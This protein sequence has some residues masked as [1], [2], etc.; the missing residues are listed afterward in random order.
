VNLK[1]LALFKIEFPKIIKDIS[2]VLTSIYKDLMFEDIEASMSSWRGILAYLPFTW[3][4][5]AFPLKVI[6]V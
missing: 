6:K 1:I 3:I 5:E 2:E 4:K